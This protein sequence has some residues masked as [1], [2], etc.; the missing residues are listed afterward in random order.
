MKNV[1][2]LMLVAATLL[3][4]DFAFAQNWT[5][6]SAPTTNW[7]AIAASADGTKL[8]SVVYNPADP[9]L[10]FA[11]P[12]FIST[13]SG[14]TWVPSGADL[15]SFGW[16]WNYIS[17]SADGSQ[18]LA[19]PFLGRLCLSKDSGVTWTVTGPSPP[20]I[21]GS[22]DGYFWTGVAS[23]QDGTKLVATAHSSVNDIGNGLIFIS[24]NSGATWT[25]ANTSF[26]TCW[27]IASAANGNELIG[28]AMDDSIY[29]S[30]NSGMA[31]LATSSTTELF[32][33]VASSADGIHLVAS[34]YYSGHIYNSK[35]SGANW[36][37]SNATNAIWQ[38]IASSADGSKLVAA[39]YGGPIYTSIDSGATWIAA[40]TPSTNWISVACSADGNELIAAA[41]GGGIWISQTTP[42]P[43]LNLVASST[44]IALSWIVPSTNFLL[45][46]SFDLTS[47]TDVTNVPVL[48]LTNLQNEMTLAPS[49][50]SGFFRLKTP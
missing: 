20:Y 47:W 46:Q 49:N 8:V 17:A 43:Q 3:A 4:A 36:T 9:L 45:Q 26:N 34:S 18:L 10:P 41:Q 48:N 38:S 2:I 22:Y 37:L 30:T 32:W 27:S 16:D 33:S 12:V 11:D 21:V 5:Q 24:T 40:N 42:S 13:N 31:W 50:P 35:D 44:N 15:G 23:S 7:V 14:A 29:I 6:T 19:A 28:G 39:A 1:K 25:E